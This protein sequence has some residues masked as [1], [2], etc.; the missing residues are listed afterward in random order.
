M[1][2]MIC[3]VTGWIHLMQSNAFLEYY[4]H[5][6]GSSTSHVSPVQPGIVREG[7]LVSQDQK[8]FLLAPYFPEDLNRPLFSIDGDKAPG[9][10]G[11]GAHFY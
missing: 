4:N 6:L 7:S 11:F 9:P 10:N 5:L 1:A 8:A 3:L 2:S